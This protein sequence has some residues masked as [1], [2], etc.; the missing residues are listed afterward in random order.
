M[1]VKLAIAPIAWTNDDLPELGGDTP[2][3]LCL[4]QIEQSG[5]VGTELGGKFPQKKEKL[6]AI[7]NKYNLELVGGWFSGLLLNLS[8]GEEKVR[9]EEEF[10][11]RK[12]VDSK[13]IVYCE[14]S[15]TIQGEIS[16]P[17]SK[18]VV[19]SQKEMEEYAKRFSKLSEFAKQKGFIL[20]YHHHMGTI[21]QNEEEL[22][23]FLKFASKDV[24]I[25]FDSGHLYFAGANPLE[26]LKKHY[27]QIA[28]VH[29]KD[30]REDIKAKAKKEDLSFLNSV[31]IGVFTIPGDGAINFKEI[32]DFLK[33]KSYSG[34]LVVEAEQDP[35]LA[36]PLEYAKK[37]YSYL[38]TLLKD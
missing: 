20:A 4:S 26:V 22:D 10:I 29:L 28:H 38:Q 24:K 25:T 7:L 27:E 3:E 36:P 14:C 11:K 18:K 8:L 16:T 32:I 33:Q 34:W 12:F 30:I 31:L 23:S 6:K 5:F 21:I 17:L 1:N 35:K 15:N 19:L 37:A 9:L 13:V 2:V